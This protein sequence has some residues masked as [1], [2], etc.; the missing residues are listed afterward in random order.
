[1]SVQN[2]LLFATLFAVAVFL[3]YQRSGAQSRAEDDPLRHGHALLI[4]NSHYKDKRW[5]PLDDVPLQLNQLKNGLEA[6]FDSVEV[7]SDVDAETLE[8]TIGNFIKTYGNDRNARL[9]VYYAGHGYTEIIGERNE[10]RG[11]ITGTDTPWV[12]G[13]T[14]SLFDAARLKAI[15]MLALRAPLEEARAKSILFVFDSCFS[16]TIFTDRGPGAAKPLSRDEVERLVGRQAR[17]IITAGTSEQVVPAHSPIPDLLLAA[18]DGGADT[19]G[20]GVVSSLEIR[21]YLVDKTRS[22][23]L[24]PQEGPLQNSA[25]TEGLF[26]FRVLK[27]DARLQDK[28]EKTK[29]NNETP[30]PLPLLP[31]EQAW[32]TISSS[33]NPK[34]IESFITNFPTSTLR[35]K[36]EERLRELTIAN[37]PPTPVTSVSTPSP[38]SAPVTPSTHAKNRVHPQAGNCFTYNGERFCN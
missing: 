4:G 28:S 22:Q 20:W 21:T 9:F 26:L 37:L 33:R 32:K 8:K 7:A 38:S 25:F 35:P 5:A 6:H 36:A 17:N 3:T 24:T 14:E 19:Y 27:Q 13:V 10:R 30:V 2:S 29:S 12:D 15:S 16:G 11:Y 1:M 23:N 34:D 31:D 18:I